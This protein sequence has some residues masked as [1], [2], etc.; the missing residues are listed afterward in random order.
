M[1]TLATT[2]PS[3]IQSPSATSAIDQAMSEKRKADQESAQQREENRLEGIKVYAEILTREKPLSDDAR[4]L[5]DLMNDPGLGLS[6][7]RIRADAELVATIRRHRLAAAK[8]PPLD[9]AK[10]TKLVADR[11]ALRKALEIAEHAPDN[12]KIECA[13]GRTAEREILHIATGRPELFQA[14][15]PGELP[16]FISE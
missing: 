1:Q 10:L 8:Y 7:D 5:A 16:K 3:A 6:E 12:Y 2:A 14:A 4:N 13:H 9:P 15:T 11:N